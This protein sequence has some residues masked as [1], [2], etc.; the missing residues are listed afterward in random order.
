MEIT[1]RE[2]IASISIICVMLIL[3][4]FISSKIT[5]AEADAKQRYNVALKISDVDTFTYGMKTNV[6]DA[7][8]CGELKAIDPVSFSEING[9]FMY[10]EKVREEYVDHPTEVTDY[11]KNGK[12]TG[13]NTEHNWSWDRMGSEDKKCKK[14]TFLGIN[15][16]SSQFGLP[17]AHHID[18]IYHG[19]DK[20]Y[21]YYA[22]ES[23]MTGSIFTSLKDNNIKNKNSFYQNRNAEELYKQLSA[24]GGVIVFWLLWIILI[25]GLV[26]GFYYYDNKW[27][28]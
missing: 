12:V 15:F 22:V 18:T 11:D 10:I 24:G 27:L 28:D 13:S 4:I 21:Q 3:G 19:S 5:E 2:I 7:F 9:E 8:V 16:K 20:R 25:G 26:Y 23:N 17:T 1:K 6:G 14:V